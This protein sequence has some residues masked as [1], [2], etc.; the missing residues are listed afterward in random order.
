MGLNGTDS[1]RFTQIH[2]NHFVCVC[3]YSN[4]EFSDWATDRPSIKLEHLDANTKRIYI[5]MKR[6]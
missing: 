2:S 3:G 1:K 5:Y 4:S 6:K